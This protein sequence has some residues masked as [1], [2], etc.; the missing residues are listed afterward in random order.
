[1]HTNIVMA[2]LVVAGAVALPA[3]ANPLVGA[4]RMVVRVDDLDLGTAAGQ[5]R[6]E[7]RL[8]RAA[9]AVCGDRVQHIHLALERQAAECRAAAVARARGALPVAVAA[10]AGPSGN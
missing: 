3:A 5:A 4:E 7:S 6:L 1:M 2:A 8:A 9:D 10:L